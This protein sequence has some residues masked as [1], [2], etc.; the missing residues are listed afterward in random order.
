VASR[1]I[2]VVAVGL[3]AYGWTFFFDSFNFDD[4][5][6][7]LGI[8]ARRNSGTIA[9]L[10]D[11]RGQ[12]ALGFITFAL[13][14]RLFGPTPQAFHVTNV[15]IHILASLS[16][17]WFLSLILS[18][19]RFQTVN[20]HPCAR[21]APLA[22]GLLFVAHPIQSQAVAYIVQRF[23]SLATLFYLVTLIFYVRGRVI[24]LRGEG[25]GIPLSLG[26]MFLS[27]LCAI[28]SKEIAATIPLTIILFE[29]V[30]FD[31]DR[32]WRVT[33]FTL[34]LLPLVIL[35]VTLFGADALRDPVSLL[36]KLRVQTNL[37]RDVY[38]FSELPVLFSYLRL[39][40]LP[41]G[42]SVEHLPPIY[43]S[44][45][46][47]PVILSA[48]THLLLIGGGVSLTISGRRGNPAKL[49]A[50]FGILWFYVTSLVESS[51]IPFI[52]LMFE[53]RV[54]LPFA[55]VCMTAASGI[56]HLRGDRW[57]AWCVRGTAALVLS[58]AT[59]TVVRTAVWRNPVT[60]WSDA[61]EKS[62]RSSRAWN[63]LAYAY[64]K[65]KQPEKA[66]PPLLTS[67]ELDPGKTD[68][69]NNLAIALDQ[70]GIYRGRYHRVYNRFSSAEDFYTSQT[71]WFA[72][73]WNNLGLIR[74][75]VGQHAA[76]IEAFRRAL[77]VYPDLAVARFNL[78]VAS[79]ATGNVAHAREEYEKLRSLAPQLAE[80]LRG[81]I[82]RASKQGQK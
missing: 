65:V 58:L 56:L 82:E 79:I 54:Y 55:G 14:H 8:N 47:A 57:G 22:A 41:V 51:V 78:G 16:L 69:W 4:T 38:F 5:T 9:E 81:L 68:V 61:V 74:E 36:A 60:L 66:I 42:Q 25:K 62:P 67:I 2:P 39:I 27:F 77:E 18:I 26:V 71:V 43:R 46:S 75:H 44:F 11:P 70:L 17:V 1:V 33:L 10:L 59:V 76:A 32:P 35:P 21:F 64:L 72:N 53:H 7:I 3:F 73:A 45:F 34:I 48:A 19:P 28:Q 37:P 40:I 63:N 29:F 31:R 24:R 15:L 49:L 80:T 13:N 12:R 23:T 6:N 52:D 50:G 20:S 30:F